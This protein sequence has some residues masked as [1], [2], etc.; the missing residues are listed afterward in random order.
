[1][2]HVVFNAATNKEK[3]INTKKF[4]VS[5]AKHY[6]EKGRLLRINLYEASYK[7]TKKK[8]SMEKCTMGTFKF[9]YN[10]QLY[11]CKSCFDK[12]HK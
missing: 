6:L 12:W 10:C 11:F 5:I 2:Q 7:N 4:A 1:V 8:C 9:C 3:K